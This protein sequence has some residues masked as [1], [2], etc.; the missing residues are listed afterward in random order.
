MEA[1]GLELSP[2]LA[3]IKA[4]GFNLKD[5]DVVKMFRGEKPRQGFI[6]VNGQTVETLEIGGKVY[7]LK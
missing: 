1:S 3:I 2:E 6:Q 4:K 7:Q 5:P